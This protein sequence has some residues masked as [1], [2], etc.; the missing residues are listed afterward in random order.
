MKFEIIENAKRQ[1]RMCFV[2]IAIPHQP[3]LASG[4]YGPIRS[5]KILKFNR[6]ALRNVGKKK[7]ESVDSRIVGSVDHM[8]FPVGKPGS[9]ERVNALIAQYASLSENEESPFGEI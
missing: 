2:G 6:K 1:A 5:E 7:S 3:S 4:E 8:R 9:V